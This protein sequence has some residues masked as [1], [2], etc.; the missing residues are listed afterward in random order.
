M[1]F[2]FK[3]ILMMAGLIFSVVVH[4]QMHARVAY[5]LGD[6]TGKDNNRFSWNPIH[7]LDP[8]QSLLLP[9]FLFL[10]TK[11]RF[12][13]GGAKPCPI[14]PNHFQ[15][16]GLGMC[17]SAAAGPLSNYALAL[18][19]FSVCVLLYRTVPSAVMAEGYLT[20]NGYFLVSFVITNAFLGSF[21]LLPIPP[22]DGSRVL[23]YFSPRDVQVVLD[24]IEPFGLFVAMGLVYL[25]AAQVIYPVIHLVY[26]AFFEATSYDFYQAIVTTL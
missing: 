7:H 13:Y 6:P 12:S 20:P 14:N 15:N 26:R 10:T 21:N 5:W 25:G 3:I 23:H 9:L 18:I 16:P 1:E 8:I 22:L 2:P 19:G 17:L 24:A 11:G 4:E